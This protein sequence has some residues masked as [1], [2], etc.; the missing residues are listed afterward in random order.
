MTDRRTYIVPTVEL[1]V[2]LEAFAAAHG[3]ADR[4][5]VVYSP[6]I[7]ADSII[8]FNPAL[9]DLRVELRDLGEAS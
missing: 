8:C 7:P 2:E 4:A 6:Y 3:L 1:A 9:L 5:E